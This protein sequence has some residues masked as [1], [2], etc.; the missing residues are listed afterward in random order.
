MSFD[1]QV[2]TAVAGAVVSLIAALGTSYLKEF[3][4]RIQ[5]R[6]RDKTEKA[7]RRQ[8]TEI[9]VSIGG[10]RLSHQFEHAGAPQAQVTNQ[11]L[12]EVEQGIVQGVSEQQGITK[13]Q[14]ATEVDERMKGLKERL[15]AIENRFPD[16]ASIDKIASINDALFAQRI[17]Q[18]SERLDK[19]E[20][21]ILSKWDVATIVSII[22][23]GIF[24]VVG[25]TYAVLKALGKAP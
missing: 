21:K 17:D 12:K 14:V 5:R 13:D 8:V 25:A 10:I 24:A 3:F 6:E 23:S 19:I 11:L 20:E 1:L 9:S 2:T 22:A 4:E 15:Q 7:A 18:L 16:E